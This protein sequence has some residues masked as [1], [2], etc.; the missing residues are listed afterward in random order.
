MELSRICTSSYEILRGRD[1][2][3]T[4]I[5]YSYMLAW[6]A[7]SF[8]QRLFKYGRLRNVRNHDEGDISCEHFHWPCLSAL[9]VGI[10]IRLV[11]LSALSFAFRLRVYFRIPFITIYFT[12]VLMTPN[13]D[14]LGDLSGRIY[15]VAGRNAG[16]FVQLFPD[17]LRASTDSIT[18][19]I[20][21]PYTSLNIMQKFIFAV[22]L[23]LKAMLP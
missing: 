5:T 15:I 20:T 19:V 12:L 22:V 4:S 14:S 13:P 23:K 21:A 16:M 3:W 1:L 2:P 6:G 18:V 8:R 9:P 10:P 17:V 7:T 11:G